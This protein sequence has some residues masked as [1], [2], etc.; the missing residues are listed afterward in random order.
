MDRRIFGKSL[1]GAAAAGGSAGLI[2]AGSGARAAGPRDGLAR[3]AAYR[4]FPDL[5]VRYNDKIRT[6]GDYHTRA[7]KLVADRVSLDYFRRFN[8]RWLTVQAHNTASKE[9]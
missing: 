1:V 8:A 3:D 5:P 2:A 7:G 6:G 9:A 4:V